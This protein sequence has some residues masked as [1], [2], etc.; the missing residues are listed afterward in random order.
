MKQK[1]NLGDPSH[2]LRKKRPL[3]PDE[4]ALWQ[5]VRKTV[6]PVTTK[7]QNLKHW[8]DENSNQPFENSISKKP[9]DIQPAP[10][11]SRQYLAPDYSPPISSP[12][13]TSK[14]TSLID[15]KTARKLVKG[16]QT[17][18]ARIDLHGMTQ[19]RAHRVLLNFVFQQYFAGSKM[20]L[21]ITGKGRMN[22]GVL[23][24]AV[25]R[26]LR[27]PQLAEFVSAFRVS[28]IAHGGEGALYVRLRNKDRLEKRKK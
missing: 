21:V 11:P 24:N 8:L 3:R 12:N 1:T 2:P 19:E 4:E 26:W 13:A 20:V 28:H 15:D 9:P 23:R 6:Q 7:R 14:F 17:I 27:E 16:K 22:E 25:P 18:D 5:Q 10:Q